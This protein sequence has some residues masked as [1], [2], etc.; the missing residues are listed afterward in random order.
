MRAPSSYAQERTGIEIPLTPLIDV[1]FQL[2]VFFLLTAGFHAAERT[3][4]S[5]IS[6]ARTDTAH[7]PADPSSADAPSAA[8]DFHDVVIRIRWVSSQPTWRIGGQTLASLADVRD[9][10]ANIAQ[11]NADAPVILHPD[12][13]VPLG[14]VVDVYD[15][16]RQVGLA[17]IQFVATSPP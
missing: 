2:L 13:D 9:L 16:A 12:P 11:I 14:H 17:T 8:L 3:L 7:T 5:P 1:V 6:A 4:P 15:A 10:L